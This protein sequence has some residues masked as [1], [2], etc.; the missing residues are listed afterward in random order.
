M[1][2]WF[3]PER[4]QAEG[5]VIR[6]YAAGDGSRL[7]EAQNESYEHLRRWMAWAVPHQAVEDA[8]INARRFYAKYLLHEDFV[9]GIFSKDEQ[10]LLGGTGFHLTEGAL[11]TGCAE[12]GM[13]I[14]A[15]AAGQG[16]GTRV[17]RAM[18]DWGFTE[19][20]WYRLSWRCDERNRASIR[21]AEKGGLLYEGRARGQKDL[22]GDG[23]RNTALYALTK[24][25]FL[26]APSAS[27]F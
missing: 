2:T 27:E 4:Y 6:T 17:L 20:P 16:L 24:Q 22:V 18:L 25:D 1:P 12:V 8:E 14:R 5:F 21:V 26:A 9:V 13:W 19:W 3:A 10:R 11:T 7:A 23:R 15:S